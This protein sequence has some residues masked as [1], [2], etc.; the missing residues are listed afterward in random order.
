MRPRWILNG[1]SPDSEKVG[2]T[3][4]AKWWPWCYLLVSTIRLDSN[5]IGAKL[6]SSLETG[7]AYEDAPPLPEQ[8]ITQVT[9]CD[10]YGIVQSWDKAILKQ[11]YSTRQEAETGHKQ[12]V[13]QFT[14]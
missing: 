1:S 14:R 11:D 7:V 2:F 10:K 5:S 12:I 8:F 6:I 13:S 9:E 4:I 3:I